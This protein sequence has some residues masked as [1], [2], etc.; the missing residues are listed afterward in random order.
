[1][2]NYIKIPLANNPAR[3]FVAGA[4]NGTATGGG[5]V[6]GTGASAAQ[7]ILGG[8]GSSATATVTK[9]G[10]ATIAS[11]TITIVG[12]G[13][14]YKVGDEVTI[15]ILGGGGATTWDAVINYT[16]VAADLVTSE[17]SATNDYQLFDVDSL[18]TV[19]GYSV[20]INL[21]QKIMNFEAGLTEGPQTI[22]LNL[23]NAPTVDFGLA[24]QAVADAMVKAIQSPNSLPIVDWAGTNV[25][26]L[27]VTQT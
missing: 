15:A 9:G 20:S 17:G 26:V 4:L 10:D 1:M 18:I 25:E 12:I 21:F 27:S 23:D 16:I 24:L 3:S 7:P 22:R 2:G 8:S 13:E 11:A 19:D 6:A 14:G 5:T